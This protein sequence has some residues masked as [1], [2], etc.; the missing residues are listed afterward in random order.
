MARQQILLCGIEA[1]VCIY[2]TAVD[3]LG[4][5]YTVDVISDAVSSRT[6]DSKETAISRMA[7]EGANIS[8]TEMVLFELL[9]TAENPQFKH[10]AKLIK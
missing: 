10:V 1:Y 9:K 4:K 2:Q 8:S 7:A 6:L 3:L 5:G